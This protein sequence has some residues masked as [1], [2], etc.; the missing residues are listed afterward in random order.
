MQEEKED[1]D[2]ETKWRTRTTISRRKSQRFGGHRPHLDARQY[3]MFFGGCFLVS[4]G[5]AATVLLLRLGFLYTFDTIALT[6]KEYV[7]K[8][9]V[10]WAKS[11]A[12]K[13][14]MQA[15][16]V[17]NLINA[18]VVGLVYREPQDYSPLTNV[19][20]P[21]FETMPN[22]H[23]VDLAFSDRTSEVTITRQKGEGIRAS[24]TFV[25]T[26]S[27]DCFLMGVE[28]CT[29]QPPLRPDW[30]NFGMSLKPT[31]HGGVHAWGKEPEIIIEGAEDGGSPSLTPSIRLHFQLTFPEY[32]SAS[33]QSTKL[34]GRITIKVVSLSGDRLVDE[35]LGPEG[36]IF[37][38]D[39][40]GATLAAKDV[41]DV[42]TVSDG[43][44]R[45]KNVW[46]LDVD[47]VKDSFTG[48]S[49]KQTLVDG[50]D[51]LTAVEP[52]ES[53]LGPRF[54]IVAIAPSW[55]PFEN[56]AL[57][58]TSGIAAIVAPA[59]YVIV[60]TISFFFFWAQCFHTMWQNDGKVGADFSQTK[61]VS[62]SATMGRRFGSTM[63]RMSF[64]KKGSLDGSFGRTKA[65]FLKKIPTFMKSNFFA[66]SG[67]GLG[68]AVGHVQDT[69]GL[70]PAVVHEKSKKN[71]RFWTNF[72]GF[73]R[74][75]RREEAN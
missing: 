38:C 5:L 17:W 63:S 39:A 72:G 42:L 26:N 11:E 18:S 59:P 56:K 2:G 62:V 67:L 10:Q 65:A 12:S 22:L 19:L 14:V 70:G 73:L 55:G 8:G 69:S 34:I 44:V 40:T 36:R 68:P 7:L 54:A 45:Y 52:L 20:S 4:W 31:L 71:S 50:G 74:R 13:D 64:S 21:A 3:T 57:I 60:G 27:N 66:K 75:R 53:P 46:E 29:P 32:R 35:R 47:G 51:T 25:Q 61:R 6:R 49:I 30:Y 43:L 24:S 28:G 9:A 16:R 1:E 33:G 41:E 23:S 58:G 37:L 48:S 15:V